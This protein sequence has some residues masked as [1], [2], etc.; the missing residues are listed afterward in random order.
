VNPPLGFSVGIDVVDASGGVVSVITP[1]TNAV[2]GV[3]SYGW[4]V[5]SSVSQGSYRV[6]VTCRDGASCSDSSDG[7]FMITKSGSSNN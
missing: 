2:S 5:P 3:N 7:T 4:I 1:K 6:R